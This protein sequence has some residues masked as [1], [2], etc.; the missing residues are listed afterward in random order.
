MRK[1]RLGAKY[2]SRQHKQQMCPN[3]G[4][5][6]SL[7]LSQKGLDF[8]RWQKAR[9]PKVHEN[10]RE[11]ERYM[12]KRALLFSEKEASGR[13]RTKPNVT[14]RCM[15]RA[16]TDPCR[17]THC[18]I[19]RSRVAYTPILL[20][21][22]TSHT[23]TNNHSTL[24]HPFENLKICFGLYRFAVAHRRPRISFWFSNSPIPFR[25][26]HHCGNFSIR[27]ISSSHHRFLLLVVICK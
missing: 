1:C 20:V 27:F 16:L 10:P 4:K 12:C 23:H 15:A 14:T 26:N 11:K 3:A 9:E 8:A 17:P 2:F 7:F 19:E 13:K 24:P 5:A 6:A 21:D 18:I 25:Q 22:Q